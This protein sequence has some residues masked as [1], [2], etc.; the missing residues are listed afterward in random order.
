MS[1]DLSKSA[2]EEGG[3]EPEY[4]A[5]GR[6]EVMVNLTQKQPQVQGCDTASDLPPKKPY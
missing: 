3:L 4:G 5:W 2:M 1:L 6:G